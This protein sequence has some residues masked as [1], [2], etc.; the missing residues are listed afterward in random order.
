MCNHSST[1]LCQ[2]VVCTSLEFIC[3][4]L[5]F[6]KPDN[7]HQNN[8]SACQT[9]LMISSTEN[10]YATV[11]FVSHQIRQVVLVDGLCSCKHSQY[12]GSKHPQVPRPGHT[13]WHLDRLP[14]PGKKDRERK[15][16][17]TTCQKVTSN[18]CLLFFSLQAKSGFF[19]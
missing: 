13:S 14:E 17:K 7:D 15:Q 16:I 12:T 18:L 6:Q 11:A 10:R 5:T 3:I 2:L 4:F 8:F 9:C 19:F 1:T